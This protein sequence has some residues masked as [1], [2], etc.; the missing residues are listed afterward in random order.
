MLLKPR[1]WLAP[2]GAA[3][4]LF[5]GT[6]P[7]MAGGIVDPGPIGPNQFFTALVN[8]VDGAS[9]IAVTCVGGTGHPVAGQTV[10]VRPATL[11]PTGP[12]PVSGFTGSA[13]KAVGV[14]L[15]ASAGTKPEVLLRFYQ[16]GAQIPTDLVVPCT[17]TGLASFVPAPTS[18]T[19]RA[20]TVKVTFVTQPLPAAG[21]VDR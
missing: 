5:A 3:A 10:E 15:G 7:A 9:Q 18:P 6:T 16:T 17:G 20:A 21:A 8:G 11:T 12:A 4:L 14:S 2:L 13:G 19:A 1:R